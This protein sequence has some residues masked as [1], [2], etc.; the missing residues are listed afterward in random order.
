MRGRGRV[1]IPVCLSGDHG[2]VVKEHELSAQPLRILGAGVPRQ[3]NQ[4]AG[5]SIPGLGASPGERQ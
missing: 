3:V 4:N 2:A 5:Y 1:A